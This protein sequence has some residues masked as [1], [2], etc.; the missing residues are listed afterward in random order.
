MAVPPEFKA[1]LDEMVVDELLDVVARPDAESR[2]A[3][4]AWPW[5]GKRGGGHAKGGKG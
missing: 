4:A 5:R 1:W 3:A 2:I